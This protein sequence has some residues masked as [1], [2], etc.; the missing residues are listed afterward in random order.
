MCKKNHIV[1]TP[2]KQRPTFFYMHL[3]I[4]SN[5]FPYIWIQCIQSVIYSDNLRTHSKILVWFLEKSINKHFFLSKS[6]GSRIQFR[7]YL[8][9]SCSQENDTAH[10][11]EDKKRKSALSGGAETDSFFW[12]F[13][14]IIRWFCSWQL[15][16][17]WI[18]RV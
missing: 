16:S 10:A 4:F 11:G 7:P 6:G 18:Y 14:R 13:S 8:W 17:P 9:A 1:N 2:Q 12:A 15:D 3:Y 5:A